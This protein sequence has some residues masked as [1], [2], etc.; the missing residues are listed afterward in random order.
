MQLEKYGLQNAIPHK[1]YIK[2]LRPFKIKLE[3][4]HKAQQVGITF[5]FLHLIFN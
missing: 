4:G 3:Q 1:I 5:V 2:K